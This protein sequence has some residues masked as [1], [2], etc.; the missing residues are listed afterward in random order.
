MT[1]FEQCV[2]AWMGVPTQRGDLLDISP[3]T[4]RAIT[5]AVLETIRDHTPSPRTVDEMCRVLGEGGFVAE[6]QID[7]GAVRLHMASSSGHG[8]VPVI[9]QAINAAGDVLDSLPPRIGPDCE[10]VA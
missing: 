9:S 3:I 7:A 6:G 10:P 5:R 2:E 1:L 4:Q 8:F